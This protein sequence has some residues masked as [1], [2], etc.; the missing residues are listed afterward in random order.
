MIYILE[1]PFYIGKVRDNM[2]ESSATSTLRDPEEWIISDSFHEPIID[3]DTWNIVQE[4]REHSKKLMQ[5]YEHPVSHTK[6]WLSGLGKCPVCGKSLSHKEGY[7][8]K[9]THGGSY[10]SGEDVYKRQVLMISWSIPRNPSWRK[11]ND[12]VCSITSCCHLRIS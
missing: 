7:P 9:S 10:I 8:R 11:L 1:N 3:M 12:T 6:H 2:R 4:R 5:R